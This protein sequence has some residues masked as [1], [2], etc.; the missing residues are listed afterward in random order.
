VIGTITNTVAFGDLGDISNT[1]IY[2]VRQI[3][4]HTEVAGS[5]TTIT[6]V[7][8]PNYTYNFNTNSS[9]QIIS[10]RTFGSPDYTTTGNMSAKNWDGQTG[11]V[12]AIHVPGTLT[13]LHNLSADLAGF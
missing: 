8:T 3:S 5:P 13:L 1:G 4:S 10:L 2:E 11:G 6:F 12:L 9:V 7:S